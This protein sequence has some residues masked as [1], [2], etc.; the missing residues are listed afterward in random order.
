MFI[1]SVQALLDTGPVVVLFD[2]HHSHISLQLLELA[3]STPV[4]HVQTA[5]V[6]YKKGEPC[7]FSTF[8]CVTMP[9]HVTTRDVRVTQVVE[10][11]CR[12]VT[13]HP[14]RVKPKKPSIT[15][16]VLCI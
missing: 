2:E 16:T 7:G 13:S 5:N 9:T 4:G 15:V 3:K 12:H 6:V 14:V 10:K 8:L 11:Q 1:S